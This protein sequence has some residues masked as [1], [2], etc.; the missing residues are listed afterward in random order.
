MADEFD[1][2]MMDSLFQLNFKLPNGQKIIGNFYPDTE[3]DYDQLEEQLAN[4]PSK[5]AFW[6]VLLGEQKYK[7]ALIEK[8][9]SRRRSKL[10]ENFLN[11]GKEEGVRLTK[12]LLDELVEADDKMLELDS[13]LIKENRVLSKLWVVVNAL[14]MKSE[15]LRS[16]AGFK[17]QELRDSL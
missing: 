10:C 8:Q 7:V 4:M 14:Q 13:R 12:Y 6:S 5:F 1:K 9:I 16:L 15:H 2:Q 17:K 3:I 11:E